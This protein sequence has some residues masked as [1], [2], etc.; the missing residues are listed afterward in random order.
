MA[1][2]KVI[3]LIGMSEKSWH[4]AVDQA[5]QEATKTVRGITDVHVVSMTGKVRNDRI[6]EYH[7][8]VK[9]AFLVEENR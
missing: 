9:L 8:N 2:I 7:A 6:A 5:L 4:D 1:T 3:E